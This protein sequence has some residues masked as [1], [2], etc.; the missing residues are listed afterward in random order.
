M[1]SKSVMVLHS[2]F[3]QC[4]CGWNGQSMTGGFIKNIPVIELIENQLLTATHLEAK[5]AWRQLYQNVITGM[6]CEEELG[7]QDGVRICFHCQSLKDNKG[8]YHSVSKT[9]LQ[10]TVC[11]K[12][13]NTIQI[14]F[15]PKKIPCPSC[16]KIIEAGPLIS[17][18]NLLQSLLKNTR[19]E[20]FNGDSDVVLLVIGET[21]S[22]N[23][24]DIRERG[25]TSSSILIE[26]KRETY[27]SDKESIS[28]L[29][30]LSTVRKVILHT[31]FNQSFESYLALNLAKELCLM[32][33]EFISV[34]TTPPIFEGRKRIEAVMEHIMKLQAYCTS[35]IIVSGA[36]LEKA[37]GSTIHL[38]KKHIP[39][40]VQKEIMTLLHHKE[41]L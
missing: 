12:C 13:G 32:K 39:F 33:V 28:L 5:N 8:I 35:T 17:S 23:V 30:N 40:Q 26:K 9:N 19:V 4:D 1:E 29:D 2:Y 41:N 36:A 38:Y 14:F 25:V 20:Y 27:S 18:S 21:A 11:N 15:Q 31:H 10:P 34:V 22:R 37:Y 24:H 16:Q 7:V 6:F 3:Y